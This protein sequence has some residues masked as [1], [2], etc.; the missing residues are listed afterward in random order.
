M[1]KYSRIAP[2]STQLDGGVQAPKVSKLSPFVKWA[3][4][5]E[6]ELKHILPAIPSFEN[7]YEPFVGGGAVFFSVAAHNKFINDKSSEL[8]NLYKMI[9]QQNK[10]F[11]YTLDILLQG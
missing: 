2:W 5:K 8:V 11:F 3:G 10:E 6:K 1:I 9:V 7:Y 4:G